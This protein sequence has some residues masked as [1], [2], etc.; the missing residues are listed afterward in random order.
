MTNRWVNVRSGEPAFSVYLL[1]T[2]RSKF[3]PK[4]SKP[5]GICDVFPPN[6]LY[7]FRGVL[8]QTHPTILFR[9]RAEQEAA[10]ATKS[11]LLA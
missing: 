1:Y 11:N 3:Q 2:K 7:Q 10:D 5:V 8:Y 4:I 9:R 6:D